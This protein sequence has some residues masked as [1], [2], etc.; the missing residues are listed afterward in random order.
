MTILSRCFAHQVAI[1]LLG[2]EVYYFLPYSLTL[3]PE[4][5]LESQQSCVPESPLEF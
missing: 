4:Y 5:Q 1:P 2:I 3:F